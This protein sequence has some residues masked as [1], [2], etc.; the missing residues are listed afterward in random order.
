MSL[1][2]VFIRF[3]QEKAVKTIKQKGARRVKPH[4][5]KPEEHEGLPQDHHCPLSKRREDRN[6]KYH[7]EHRK[8]VT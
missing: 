6:S 4:M 8:D 2:V 1:L 3:K 7:E 5:P